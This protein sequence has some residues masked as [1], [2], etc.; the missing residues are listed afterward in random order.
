MSTVPLPTPTTRWR[1]TRCG[2][3]TRFDVR[4]SSTVRE[5]VHLDLAGEPTVE[6]HDVIAETVES[7]RCR[8]CDAVDAVELVPRP[9]GSVERP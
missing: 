1:C 8:W 2:N 5:F 6:E 9:D 4:R 3:L 7:V